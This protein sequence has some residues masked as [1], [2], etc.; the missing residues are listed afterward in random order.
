MNIF[1]HLNPEGVAH[2]F[3][4]FKFEIKFLSI[5]GLESRMREGFKQKYSLLLGK[6]VL[7]H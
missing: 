4:P 3:Y 1:D 6:Y 7:E 5:L 2:R